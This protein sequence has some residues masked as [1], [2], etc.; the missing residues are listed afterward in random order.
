[1]AIRKIARDANTGRFIS[2]R[3]ARLHPATTVVETI[4]VSRNGAR[5]LERRRSLKAGKDI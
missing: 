4:R 5:R 1:M 3:N 2:L